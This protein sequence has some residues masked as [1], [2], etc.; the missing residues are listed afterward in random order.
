MVAYAAALLAPGIT[1]HSRVLT[2][3]ETIFAQPAREMLATGDWLLPR[4]VGVPCTHKPPL[5]HWLIALTMALTGSQAAWAA[6]LPSVLAAAAAAGLVGDLAARWHGRRVG[7]V[8][9][10]ACSSAMFVIM[11]ARLAEADM[12]LCLWVTMAL[13]AVAR[14]R[15]G[16]GSIAPGRSWPVMVW[17]AIALSMMTKSIIGPA[18]IVAG[19]VAYAVVVRDRAALGMLV[20]PLG[21]LIAGLIVL[22]WHVAAWRIYPPILADWGF[23][24]LGRFTGAKQPSGH[25]LLYVQELPILLAPWTLHVGL[26]VYRGVRTGQW[27]RRGWRLIAAQLAVGMV[28][29]SLSSFRHKHYI[30][31]LL[32]LTLIWAGYAL[33][34]VRLLAGRPWI[35][36]V[37]ALLAA[38][39]GCGVGVW[40]VRQGAP[41]LA[42]GVTAIIVGVAVLAGPMIVLDWRGRG[43]A[44]VAVAMAAVLF[45]AVGVGLWV[46]PAADAREYA[47]RAEL[48]RRANDLVPPG[49]TVYLLELPEDQITFYIDRPMVRV[50]QRGQFAERVAGRG[51]V[52][53]IAP[54]HRLD[55]LQAVGRAEILAQ[56]DRVPPGSPA[57]AIALAEVN[58]PGPGSSPSSAPAR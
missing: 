5:T 47:P 38:W 29:L 52:Y 50:D 1:E 15:A 45:A 4:F 8:T 21:W 17:T 3:H 19:L 18:L 40:A 16:R 48:A 26:G 56:C 53:V 57:G 55:V 14:D 54:V 31:P 49:Q 23:H 6:R 46:M 27:A 51:R 41:D 28:I 24:T 34:D 33:V 35:W 30:A 2:Y 9:G 37:A 39:A 43:L 25:A 20:S 36:M 10:L 11:Q 58:A 22:P 44:S 7:V 12:L 13:Y 32:P 42:P